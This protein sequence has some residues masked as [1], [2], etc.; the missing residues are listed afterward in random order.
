MNYYPHHIGD[1]AKDTRALSQ[2]EHGA[3]RLLID[4]AYSSEN[5]VDA[6]EV[7]AI[8]CAHTAA[9]R[10]NTDR[11][12]TKFFTLRDGRYYQKRID[13]EV[14]AYRSKSEKAKMAAQLSVE[15]RQ[16]QNARIRSERLSAAREKGAHTKEEWAALVDACGNQC[17]RCGAA[18]GVVKD[19][20]KPIYQGGSDGIDNL[21]PLCAKCNASK[22]PEDIDHVPLSVRSAFAQRSLS[23]RSAN[24]GPSVE[25]TINQE[26][27]TNNQ[28]PK[29]EKTKAQPQAAFVCPD[30]VPSE[31]W[32]GW[33]A[34][35][36]AKRTPNSLH[37]LELAV[38]TLDGLRQSGF[39]PK[40]VL[41]QSTVRGWTGLFEVKKHTDANS[42]K[43]R[44][45]PER[46]FKTIDYRAGVKP[47]GRF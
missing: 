47:D 3:Y 5:G 20:V 45:A 22:G 37:A 9:E 19:H 14:V 42:M 17:V 44:F 11:V 10:K 34:M 6:E 32:D 35:R 26:P 24:V 41:D 4:E 29:K 23:V 33:V 13:E 39:D 28:E 18:D 27:I 8:S 31:A 12:L 40:D 38:K 36:K 16:R 30:W 25:L 7:Y 2:A 1:Y 46:D 43:P 21:Q 15:A